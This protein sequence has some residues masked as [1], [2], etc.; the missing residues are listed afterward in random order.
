MDKYCEEL[1]LAEMLSDPLTLV[2]MKADG[3]GPHDLDATVA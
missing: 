2:L 3:V 1:T